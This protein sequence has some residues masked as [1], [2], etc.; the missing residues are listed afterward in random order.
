MQTNEIEAK[1]MGYIRVHSGFEAHRGYLGMSH[2]GECP[3]KLYNQFMNG[4]MSDDR[5]HLG[6]FAGYS[7]EKIEREVLAGAGI[8]KAG[9]VEG[10]LV[11]GFDPLLR[12]HIDGVT[13]DG[14]LLEIKSV[15]TNKFE[16]IIKNNQPMAEHYFQV[17]VYM[18]FGG[19]SQ[20]V[21]VYVA[22]EFFQHKV[23]LVR[24]DMAVTARLV[25]NARLVLKAIHEQIPPEC[26][27]KKCEVA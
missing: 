14:D 7:M 10:E 3:R 1:I 22:R 5:S 26:T 13:V 6:A 16:K 27:C 25:G 21:I 9:Y 8:L 20:A 12:G 4:Q 15:S 24:R 23:F 11:A 17:Q 19:Y 2:L 18:H